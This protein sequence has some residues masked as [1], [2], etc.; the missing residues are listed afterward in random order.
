LAGG[1]FA[2]GAAGV[3]GGCAVGGTSSAVTGDDRSL[4]GSNASMMGRLWREFM[5][6]RSPLHHA[7]CRH[8]RHRMRRA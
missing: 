1:N 7:Q 3:A 8:S 6:G 4:R 5:P 2:I